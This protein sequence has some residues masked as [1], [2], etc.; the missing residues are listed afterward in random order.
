[1]QLGNSY[2]VPELEYDCE[3]KPR[4]LNDIQ[5]YSFRSNDYNTGTQLTL[6]NYSELF[7]VLYFDL[8]NF[9]ESISDDPK[10]LLFHYRLNVQ[11]TDNYMIYAVVLYEETIIIDNI[12]NELVVV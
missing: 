3:F 10:Q 2:F 1:M 9:K 8:R 4:L 11:A 6:Q 12:G 7:P 5:G